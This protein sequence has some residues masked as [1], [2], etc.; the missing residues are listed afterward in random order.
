[1]RMVSAEYFI[2]VG[3]V[4]LLADKRPKSERGCSV[5]DDKKNVPDAPRK[6]DWKRFD[7]PGFSNLYRTW[8]AIMRRHDQATHAFISMT[9]RASEQHFGDE[10]GRAPYEAVAARL[11]R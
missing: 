3:R 4:T 1:M 7:V 11:D 6:D 8:A 5:R 10:K 2:T 9:N